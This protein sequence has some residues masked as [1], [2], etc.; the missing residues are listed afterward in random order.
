M[1]QCLAWFVSGLIAW[2]TSVIIG[3]W[4]LAGDDLAMIAVFVA[5]IRAT[6]FKVSGPLAGD[7]ATSQYS[8]AGVIALSVAGTVNWC[9]WSVLASGFA[10]SAIPA[11]IIFAVAECWILAEPLSRESGHA[12]KAIRAWLGIAS[13]PGQLVVQ[14]ESDRLS[15]PDRCQLAPNS[16]DALAHAGPGSDGYD[17]ATSEAIAR[18]S[19]DGVDANGNRYIAGEIRTFIPE[20]ALLADVSLVFHPRFNG[21]PDLEMEVDVES[22]DA[23]TTLL[24]SHGARIQLKRPTGEVA[25]L[26]VTIE[27]YA[28]EQVDAHLNMPLEARRSLLP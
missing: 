8:A 10:T 25:N 26:P 28:S 21:T 16:L 7:A 19:T 17:E 23:R 22:V 20:N 6:A 14:P 3:P 4:D 11:I 24:T 13:H 2:L 12:Q 1:T 27:W 9:G 18:A 5:G 15:A